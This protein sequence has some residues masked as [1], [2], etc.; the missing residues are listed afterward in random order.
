MSTKILMRI[1]FVRAVD[2]FM[3]VAYPI[4]EMFRGVKRIAARKEA[5]ANWVATQHKEISS[6]DDHIFKS[7]V[8]PKPAIIND[9]RSQAAKQLVEELNAGMHTGEIMGWYDI[10]DVRKEFLVRNHRPY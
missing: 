3:N 4:F 10:D 6:S 1:G 2:D 9:E 5:Y 8:E 7:L